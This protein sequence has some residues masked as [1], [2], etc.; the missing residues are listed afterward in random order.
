MDSNTVLLIAAAIIIFMVV[1]PGADRYAT[2]TK[3]EWASRKANCKAWTN[4]LSDYL[5]CTRGYGPGWYDAAQ[6]NA[7]YEKAST[8]CAENPSLLNTDLAQANQLSDCISRLTAVG[9]KPG[10]SIIYG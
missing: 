1:R 9:T 2:L 10:T 7:M 4:D 6:E 3:P 5:T 8:L